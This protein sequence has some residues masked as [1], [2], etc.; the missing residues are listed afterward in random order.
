MWA[1]KAERLG[2][3][4]DDGPG[5]AR[6]TAPGSPSVIHVTDRCFYDPG[7]RS[8]LERELKLDVDSGFELPP[9]AGDELPSR[10]F[11][12]TYHDTPTRSLARAGITLRRRIENG[13]S[14]WQLKLPGDE[15]RT[16]LESPGGPAGPPDELRR[17]LST[18]LRHG[19]LEPVATMRT[20]RRGVRVAD[21]ERR[22]ADVTIDAVDVLDAGRSAGRFVEVE[23][24]LVDGDESDLERLGRTLR[25]AGAR[26]SDG[27][28]KLL[29]VLRLDEAPSPHR[30]ATLLEHLRHLLLVQLRELEAHDPGVRLGDDP[31]D[32]H[33]FRVATRRS[34]ALARAT[35]PLLGETLQP[36][37]AELKWLAGVVGEVRDL[38]VLLQRLRAEVARLDAD[39]PAGGLIVAQ[40]EEEREAARDALV[41][42]LDSDRYARLLD[43]FDTAIASLPPLDA[44]GGVARIAA[45]ELRKLRKAA[46]RLPDNPPDAQLH[47]VRIRAKR[48]RYTAELAALGGGKGI[49]AYVDALKRVQ[50]V[51]GEHQDAVVAEE[52]LR[53]LA[54]ARTAVAAGRLIELER[55]RK[56]RMRAAYPGAVA[57]ALARG[58]KAL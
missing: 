34:R 21:D 19:R 14:V 23:V 57:D 51:I 43:A 29:R 20:R 6:G 53:R 36:L 5:G 35:R 7:V 22:V 32:V 48:A 58:A 10:V 38:D 56:R 37:D 41:A 25:R 8:T 3:D 9:L 1:R 52:R 50:D 54:R 44:E 30:D 45:A 46:R 27:C 12:S 40:L 16:E 24:E 55:E 11:T 13:L 42:A 2:A 39:T 33:R 17:L 26:R 15:G 49:G 4:G 47:K 18:H 31:E 28:P